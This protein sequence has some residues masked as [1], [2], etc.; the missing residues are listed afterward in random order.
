MI[1]LNIILLC[2]CYIF[3]ICMFVTLKNF[4]LTNMRQHLKMTLLVN[5]RQ[6]CY[7]SSN[8]INLCAIK[9][10]QTLYSQYLIYIKWIK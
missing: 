3:C 7:F 1:Y 5:V 2:Q 4:G 6:I 8:A 9:Q 10:I